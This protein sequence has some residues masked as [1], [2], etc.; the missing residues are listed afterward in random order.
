MDSGPHRAYLDRAMANAAIYIGT[1][2][3]WGITWFIMTFQ[4]GV[5][6]PEVSVGYRFILASAVL[7]AYCAVTG[8]RLW[9]DRRQHLAMAFQGV[10]IF[11]INYTLIYFA[12]SRLSTGL[13]AVIFSTIIVFN[14]LFGALFFRAIVR[15]QVVLGALCGMAGTATVFAPELV[16][17]DIE[18]RRFTGI[19]MS[20]LAVILASLGNMIAVRNQR[21]GLPIVQTNAYSM[22]YSGLLVLGYAVVRG[23]PFT[24]DP[25][26][27]YVASLGFLAV[28]ATA[29]GF[30]GYL[31]LLGRL[32][33]DRAA[34]IMVVFP[35]VALAMSTVFEDF[36]WTTTA[37][38]GI[39]LVLLGN[40]L[41]LIKLP[42]AAQKREREA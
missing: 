37:A 34:Y 3:I 21:L 11:A 17:F 25:S 22:L 42:R 20:L 13:I 35:I 15:P 19:L 16:A 33:A 40:L 18:S 27:S 5:V 28:V 39:A 24:F 41:T 10:F 12:A 6:P 26:F 9:F 30:G 38:A 29:I 31:T 14:I 23:L 4:L 7:I 36:H 2:L 32:G 8:R 1:V